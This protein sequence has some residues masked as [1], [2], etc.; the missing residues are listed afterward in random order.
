MVIG[1]TALAYRAVNVSI[2]KQ[3]T[4]QFSILE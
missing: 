3:L 2:K 1:L 4:R